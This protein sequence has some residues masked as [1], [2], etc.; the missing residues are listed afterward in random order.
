MEQTDSKTLDRALRAASARIT[1]GLSPHAAAAAWMDWMSHLG[2]SPGRIN[3]LTQDALRKAADT[4]LAVAGHGEGPQPAPGDHRFD[5][6]GWDMPPFKFWKT[7]FLAQED[8]WNEA[9]SELR[10]MRKISADR[11][12]FMVRQGLDMMSPSNFPLTNPEVVEKTVQMGGMNFMKGARHM[13]EDTLRNISQLPLTDEEGFEVGKDLAVTPGA[14]VYR[15]DLFELI[16]YTPQT[17]RV[18]AEPLL[19]VPAWIMKYYILDLSPPKSLIAHL[20]AQ[21]YTV[22]AISWCNP[23]ADQRDLSLEDYRRRG[24]VEAL[25]AV[26]KITRARKVHACGYCL[27]GTIL[28]ITAAAMARDG[29]D[30]LASVTLLAGQTDFSEAGELMLFVDDS[31]IAFLEDMMWDKG[32]LD[33]PQMAGAFQALRSR[34]LVWSRLLRRYLLGEEEQMFDMAA[35]NMD[36][37][38]M[39]YRMHSEYLRGLFLENRL[40]AGRF[41]VEGRVIALKDVTAPFFVLGTEK[42]HIAPWR[43]VYKTALFTDGDLSFVLTSGGHNSGVLSVPGHG[44]RHYRIGHRPPG[45]KYMDPDTWIG[46]HEPVEGSWWPIWV[47]WLSGKSSGEMIAPPPLG[48]SE[49]GL[50]PLMPAPGTF[51][52]QK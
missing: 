51:V 40:T 28:A 26:Q 24:V 49:D 13:A 47:D 30:R 18:H 5:H 48:R 45:R 23:T 12:N 50:P 39:P 21:G 34:D 38:R 31:Q 15:N 6:P 4:A 20:V 1:G 14:V 2:T 10:G 41:S 25:D 36:A 19:I 35:W 17:D 29:D 16:Q 44:H 52:L 7:T 9:T 42:D 37:T 32:Y 11:V 8:W 33:A 22:F 46:R 43:S 27:G 3:A